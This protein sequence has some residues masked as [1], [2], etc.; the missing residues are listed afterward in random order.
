M[1]DAAM[2]PC[3]RCGG[4]CLRRSRRR[5]FERALSLFNLYPY[6]CDDCGARVFRSGE[7]NLAT[8]SPS[9]YPLV[10]NESSSREHA[11]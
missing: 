6:R 7:R 8:R 1:S 11:E 5:A 10:S 9:G 4:A 2:S 3:R